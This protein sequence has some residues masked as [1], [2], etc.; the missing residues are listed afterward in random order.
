MH[1]A[2][3]AGATWSYSVGRVPIPA[4]SLAGGPD[5]ELTGRRAE[6]AALDRLA[7]AVRS[8]ASQALV[9]HGDAGVGKSALLEYLAGQVR[10]L[11]VVRAAGVQSEMELAFAAVHQ[12]CAPMLG[13]LERLPGP[14]RDALR[15][16][17]GMSA[18]P[19][20]DRFLVGLA[21]L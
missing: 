15:T 18:G 20:P 14:Q 4:D 1:V 3:R 6:C 8:G 16:V 12:L 21:V 10:D 7:A 9:I 13:H 19:A 11:Q 2:F 5:A 17:F